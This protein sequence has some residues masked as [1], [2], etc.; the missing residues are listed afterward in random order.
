MFGQWEQSVW[1]ER[2]SSLQ[3]LQQLPLIFEHCHR[4]DGA[5]NSLSLQPLHTFQYRTPSAAST[6][7]DFL[8][9]INGHGNGIQRP[10]LLSQIRKHV[11]LPLGN[12]VYMTGCAFWDNPVE[13]G[14]LV[15]PTE[16]I[17]RTTGGSNSAKLIWE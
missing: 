2:S 9:G 7:T 8:P 17:G 15:M 12:S 1:S 16:E 5:Y 6:P 3:L 11:Q 4:N 10:H 14:R 13:S